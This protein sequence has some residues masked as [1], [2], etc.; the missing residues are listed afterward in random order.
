MKKVLSWNCHLLKLLINISRAGEIMIFIIRFYFCCIMA[1]KIQLNNLSVYHHRVEIIRATADQIIKDF[2]I[3]GEKIE[4][5]G[6]T[7]TAYEELKSQ[8]LPVVARL[9]RENPEKFL[10]LLYR[11]D[12]SEKTVK[13]ISGNREG[14]FEEI[15]SEV[16]IERE[17]KKVIIRKYYRQ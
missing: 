14:N 8:V 10:S 13:E 12:V 6:N 17:L 16:I 11:I 1:G 15:I 3:F 9:M 7:G 4:F 2:E 5:S